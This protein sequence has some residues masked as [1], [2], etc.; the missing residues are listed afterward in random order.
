MRRKNTSIKV[1]T[2]TE[3]SDAAD[4]GEILVQGSGGA[5][6]ISQMFR[7]SSDEL[8][9][10][11]V[12]LQPIIYQDDILCL[13]DSLSSVKAGNVKIDNLMFQKKLVLNSDKT[14]FIMMEKET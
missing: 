5:V 1:R 8:V 2:G 11:T 14:G 6:L 13:S 12:R 3:V 9:Y 4:V 10:G 7:G